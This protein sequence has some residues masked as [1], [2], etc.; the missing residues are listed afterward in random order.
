MAQILGKDADGLLV[1][2]LFKEVVELRLDGGLEEPLVTV[3]DGL[4][5]L[6]RRVVASAH[7]LAFQSLVGRFVLVGQHVDAEHPLVLA[8]EEGKDAVRGGPH[9]VLF[10]VEP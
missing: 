4:A 2:F 5:D 1:G 8:A 9:G 6:L 10:P 7:K 3:A